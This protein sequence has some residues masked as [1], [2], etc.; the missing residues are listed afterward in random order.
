MTG[1]T[2]C[3]PMDY[4][5]NGAALMFVKI[6]SSTARCFV[7]ATVDVKIMNLLSSATLT[8]GLTNTYNFAAPSATID[9]IYILPVNTVTPNWPVLAATGYAAATGT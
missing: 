3:T 7:N 8:P 1:P 9:N 2:S 5:Y 4:Y 6:F